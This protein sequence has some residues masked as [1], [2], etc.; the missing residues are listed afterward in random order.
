M[1]TEQL[2]ELLSTALNTGDSEPLKSLMKKMDLSRSDLAAVSAAAMVLR[3]AAYEY[4]MADAGK[5]LQADYVEPNPSKL[6]RSLAR[7]AV[8]F[9]SRSE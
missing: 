3:Q 9:P 5:P 8:M 1:K 2:T 4:L 6:A 7:I